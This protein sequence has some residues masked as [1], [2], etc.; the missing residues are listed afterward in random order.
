[1][2]GS[3]KSWIKF[4]MQAVVGAVTG[5]VCTTLLGKAHWFGQV[6]D[7]AGAMALFFVGLT[8]LVGGVAAYLPSLHP[9]L[10]ARFLFVADE[11]EL[12]DLRPIMLASG[13]VMSAIGVGQ[14]L[15]VLDH[16]NAVPPFLAAVVMLSSIALAI[17]V[18]IGQWRQYDEFWKQV[19]MEGSQYTLWA[20]LV[21]LIGWATLAQF[22]WVPAI[23]P[24]GLIALLM[25][26]ALV[27]TMIAAQRRGMA[28][29][30]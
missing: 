18:T 6:V 24:L 28:R 11:E 17:G 26:L 13:I 21:A 7:N 2:I 3:R 10:G 25:G 16:A 27:C 23:N 9:R 20:V 30:D 19:S 4:L 15:L 1:M 12:R 5:F 8:Y 29:F 14:I 22:G